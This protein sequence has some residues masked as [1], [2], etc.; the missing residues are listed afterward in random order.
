MTMTSLQ[1]H[2]WQLSLGKAWQGAEP[3]L[4]LQATVWQEG[5]PSSRR[6]GHLIMDARKGHDMFRWRDDKPSDVAVAGPVN[7][8][9]RKYVLPGRAESLVMGTP[10]DPNAFVGLVIASSDDQGTSRL[11]AIVIT[12]SNQP[13]LSIVLAPNTSVCRWTS[14]GVYTVRKEAPIGPSLFAV[15]QEHQTALSLLAGS[16]VTEK[17]GIATE[18]VS[19]GS[20]PTFSLAQ[21]TARDRVAR[22]I[23]TLKKTLAEETRKSATHIE[24]Q[25]AQRQ[26]ELL[27]S[28]L[29]LIKPDAV[30]LRLSSE[31]T[32][33]TEEIIE[34]DPDR[35]PGE[36]M[37][38][39]F[40]K[41]RRLDRSVQMGHDR[42]LKI[43]KQIKEF[44]ASLQTLRAG[45]LSTHDVDAIMSRLGFTTQQTASKHQ[46]GR[47]NQRAQKS[48][49]VGRLFTSSDNALMIV[50]RTAHENDQITKRAKSGDWWLHTS[51]SVQ[52]AHVVVPVRSLKGKILTP[53]TLREAG[54]LAVHFSN[55]SLSRE[56]EVYVTQRVHLR[57]RKG[58]PEG[59]W[60][61][62]RSETVMI[63]YE[64]SELAAIFTR[65]ERQGSMRPTHESP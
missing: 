24:A 59:L 9:L 33:A 44:E 5:I 60:H 30:Q 14:Q 8:L 53:A 55:L 47:V 61:V 10:D 1:S 37:N 43:T 18:D 40:A 36:Q 52:G 58:M 48:Q 62:E 45:T 12:P 49:D 31:Q 50:G 11:T 22:R 2:Q 26:A 3:W 4:C 46:A 28:Y 38:A 19:A 63:R 25:A 34:L 65:E 20:T 39:A 35:S 51:G 6:R 15:A 16:L 56:G 29:H 57:K 27:K 41:A 54:I 42:K 17:P 32:G 7:N 13:E 21:R 23:K 64:Q